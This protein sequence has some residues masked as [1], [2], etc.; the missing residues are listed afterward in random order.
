[1]RFNLC[2]GNV[3]I[4]VENFLR[5]WPEL[6]QLRWRFRGQGCNLAFRKRNTNDFLVAS[7]RYHERRRGTV[8]RR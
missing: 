3:I 5:L 7:I 4:P 6:Q 1:M 8:L 2:N